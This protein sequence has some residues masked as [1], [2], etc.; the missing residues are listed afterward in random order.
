[1]DGWGEWINYMKTRWPIDEASKVA[2]FLCGVLATL[3]AGIQIAGSIRRRKPEVGD[4]EILYIPQFENRPVDWLSSA[5]VSLADE[6]IDAWLKD[7]V[8]FKRPN[9]A[10]ITSWGV[11]NKLAVHTASGIPVD[12]FSTTK[13]KWWASLV[14]RTGSKETNLK[15]AT[16]AQK[17]GRTLNAYGS[18]VTLR[19][20]QVLPAASEEAVFKLCGVPYLEPQYR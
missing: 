15:L 20:G 14:I 3:C 7:G 10:G 12:F 11:Q 9:K 4:I 5:P 18:G 16:G 13:S 17:M 1:M 19:D 8:L 6:Q 2:D